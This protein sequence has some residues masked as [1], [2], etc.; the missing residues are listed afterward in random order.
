MEG[1]AMKTLIT[2]LIIISSTALASDQQI[3]YNESHTIENAIIAQVVTKKTFNETCS[4]YTVSTTVVYYD[5]EWREFKDVLGSVIDVDSTLKDQKIAAD[6][7]AKAWF[8]WVIY[9]DIGKLK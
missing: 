7:M 5:E 9:D 2:I 1:V 3:I 6:A 4:Y 8:G